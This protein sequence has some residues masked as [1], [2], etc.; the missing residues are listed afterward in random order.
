MDD[1]TIR[2]TFTGER[3]GGSGGRWYRPS[4][5]PVESS[6]EPSEEADIT[7]EAQEQPLVSVLRR[8]LDNAYVEI[9]E[10]SAI[11]AHPAQ[12]ADVDNVL[13]TLRSIFYR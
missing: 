5:S 3:R 9:L 4:S 12:P 2:E 10:S 11:P 6:E 8:Q 1:L 7:S 13:Q